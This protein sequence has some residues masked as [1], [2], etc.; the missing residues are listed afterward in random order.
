MSLAYCAAEDRADHELGVRLLV[1]SLARH[2]GGEPLLLFFPPA[3]HAF[4]TWLQRFPFV[5]LIEDWPGGSGWAIKPSALRYTL[6]EFDEAVWIDADIIVTSNPRS[7]FHQ[8][9]RHTMVVVEEP[10]TQPNHG[11]TARTQGLGLNVGRHLAITT[12]SCVLRVTNAHDPLLQRW[13]TILASEEYLDSQRK[14]V[15]DR[16]LSLMGDQDVL[17]GLLGSTMFSDIQIRYLQHGRDIIHSGG[18]LAYTPKER[19]KNIYR[20]PCFIHG[21][22]TKPWK[23]FMPP[24]LTKK[25][26]FW[27]YR[28]LAQEV[29]P[30]FAES[31]KYASDIGAEAKWM[32]YR[33][34]A[35]RLLCAIGFGS[36]SLRGLPISIGAH[37]YRR[38]RGMQM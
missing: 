31:K 14:Q 22:G 8:E 23:I 32:S 2:H 26:F 13:A 9:N 29:S 17:C 1:A 27:Q 35:G 24:D 19:L 28:R 33:S 7:M 36:H 12:N 18:L 5:H 15:E 11:S 10:S 6:R 20:S 3:D 30:Y 21:Q 16:P 37:L 38:L 25:G 34:I 4:R